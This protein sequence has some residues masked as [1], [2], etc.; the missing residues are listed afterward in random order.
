MVFFTTPLYPQFIVFFKEPHNLSPDY[1][2]AIQEKVHSVWIIGL[3]GA[4]GAGKS[5][6]SSC[7][8]KKGVPLH[9]ADHYVHF[10]LENDS[11]VQQQV[12]SLWP[13]VW[14]NGKIDRLLLGN[15]VLSSPSDLNQLESLLYPKVMEDQI[16][17]IKKNQYHR[18]LVIV[19]DIPL[20]FEVGL[21]AYCDY[22]II[23]SAS[24]SL[25]KYRVMKRKGM[26]VKKFH[27][28]ENLQVT[29]SERRKK[30]D[31]IIYSGQSKGN[32][33]KIVQHILWVLSQRP[34]L[35]WQGKWPKNITRRPYESRSCSR[36][37][38]NRI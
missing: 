26:T 30:A 11:D 6:V 4:I 29:D 38:N 33:L 12:K 24:P 13:D 7:F 35:K 25:R 22:V 1:T 23:V 15:R 16:R 20:L 36:Y 10:L 9:C 21:D 27:A 32:S 2:R 18:S 19:L 34:P 37:R 3:T 28:I 14:V 8:R 31:F 17:F 5:T